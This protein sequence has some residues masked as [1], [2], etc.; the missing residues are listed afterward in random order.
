MIPSLRRRPAAPGP[1]RVPGPR[2]HAEVVA[3]LD[4]CDRDTGRELGSL[5]SLPGGAARSAEPVVR[6]RFRRIAAIF[7]TPSVTSVL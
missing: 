1:D 5:G 7:R 6:F 4:L 3:C 2:R